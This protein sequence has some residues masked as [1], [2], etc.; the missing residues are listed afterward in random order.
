ML[1]GTPKNRAGFLPVMA[2]ATASIMMIAAFPAKALSHGPGEEYE[3]A[4]GFF[5]IRS[6]SPDYS[7]RMTTPHILPGSIGHGVNIFT[8]STVSNV[9]VNGDLLDLDFEMLDYNLG[10][11]YGV[12]HRVGFAFIYDQ[13]NYFGGGARRVDPEFSFGHGNGPGWT[14]PGG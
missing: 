14:R 3:Y 7:L 12:N 10:I 6:Q 8:G 13:R 1:F 5:H 9:W 4:S 2:V 11:T